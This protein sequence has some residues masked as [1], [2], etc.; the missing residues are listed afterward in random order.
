MSLTSR[1]LFLRGLHSHWIFK[2]VL[3]LWAALGATEIVLPFLPAKWSDW[4]YGLGYLPKWH[5]YVWTVGVLVILIIG[6]FEGGHRQVQLLKHRI[7]QQG[8]A[9]SAPVD[10]YV[11]L[12]EERRKLEAELQPLLEGAGHYRGINEIGAVRWKTS[13]DNIRDAKIERLTRDIADITK[14]LAASPTKETDEG[15]QILLECQWPPIEHVGPGFPVRKRQIIVKNIRDEIAFNIRFNVVKI[16]GYLADFGTIAKV[17]KG[18][19]V[20]VIAKIWKE[21]TDKEHFQRDFE[22]LLH[23]FYLSKGLV[24]E[25]ELTQTVPL[26]VEYEDVYGKRYESVHTLIYD[27]WSCSG[28]IRF[29]SYKKLS[30]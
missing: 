24:T 2:A 21:G 20:G 22:Y 4:F 17:E 12:M 30:I 13:E 26:R 25:T 14:R 3:A 16:D 15:P 29:D 28:E 19:P 23:D 10:P 11:A 6:V 1:W 27:S 18:Y 9:S 7:E 8:G 5:W